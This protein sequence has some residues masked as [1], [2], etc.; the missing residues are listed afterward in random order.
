MP[1]LFTALPK[2]AKDDS[3]KVIKK[4]TKVEETKTPVKQQEINV[5]AVDEKANTPETQ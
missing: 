1:F 5:E 2:K 3:E 4:D